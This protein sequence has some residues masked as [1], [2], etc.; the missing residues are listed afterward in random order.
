MTRYYQALGSYIEQFKEIKN[1]PV[2]P[3]VLEVFLQVKRLKDLQKTISK[4]F[5]RVELSTHSN[6]YQQTE[7]VFDRALELQKEIESEIHNVK[8]IKCVDKTTKTKDIV[9]VGKGYLD[10]GY[11]IR[12]FVDT[13][14]DRQKGLK[15]L[16]RI[17]YNIQQRDT[18]MYGHMSKTQLLNVIQCIMVL[19]ADYGKR[20]A[21]KHRAMYQLHHES[22][23]SPKV[24]S[25][26][27]QE[28]G[29]YYII[30]DIMRMSSKHFL[31]SER[32]PQWIMNM[33]LEKVG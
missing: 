12:A 33:E 1:M 15:G 29:L 7:K 19:V 20:S 5:R 28:L 31:K 17:Y 18:E 9:Y 27:M 2:E 23:V 25:G 4:Y 8:K 3:S 14:S 21:R 22:Q 30:I 13:F 32:L 6:D 24:L 11:S 26:I 16:K 10:I